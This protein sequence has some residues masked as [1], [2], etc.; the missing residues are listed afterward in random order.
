MTI[1]SSAFGTG[2]RVRHAFSLNLFIY[3]IQFLFVIKR[4]WEDELKVEFSIYSIIC[5]TY[6]D[7]INFF[8]IFS[9][10]LC[11]PVKYDKLN[12]VSH[13]LLFNWY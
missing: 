6:F 5:V 4:I 7:G 1:D 11:V 2:A 8:Y 3:T 13:Y 12:D 9:I 10:Y